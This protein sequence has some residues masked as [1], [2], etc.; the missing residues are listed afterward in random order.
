MV[1]LYKTSDACLPVL[2][3]LLL[4]NALLPLLTLLL[5]ALSPPPLL[6]LP[7]AGANRRCSYHRYSYCQDKSAPLRFRTRLDCI[8]TDARR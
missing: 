2:L 5:L 1:A 6:L 4:F 7:A 8:T 3:L